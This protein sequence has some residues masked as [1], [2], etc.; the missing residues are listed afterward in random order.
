MVVSVSQEW[1]SLLGGSKQVLPLHVA[2]S[3][4]TSII[5]CWLHVE[6]ND[7]LNTAVGIR[8][9][10]VLL[11]SA[12]TVKSKEG[13]REVYCW[14]TVNCLELW[15]KVLA[16]HADK[17]VFLM[18]PICMPVTLSLR[19]WSHMELHACIHHVLHTKRRRLHLQTELSCCSF[20]YIIYTSIQHV[21][22]CHARQYA[23]WLYN[24]W[25]FGLQ[26]TASCF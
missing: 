17:Q 16:A 20:T 24:S 15:A 23:H 4:A 6:S 14:Q 22:P 10:A 25:E 11:R 12:L 18:K 8:Q 26:Q 7:T 1:G 5:V 21:I 19:K 3:P 9:L 2:R 13:F